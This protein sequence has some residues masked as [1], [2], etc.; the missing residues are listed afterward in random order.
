M[1]LWAVVITRTANFRTWSLLTW[2]LLLMS[3]RRDFSGNTT[4][5]RDTVSPVVMAQSC[6][7]CIPVM[8]TCTLWP[9]AISPVPFGMLSNGIW[10]QHRRGKCRLEVILNDACLLLKECSGT[11]LHKYG[12]LTE[13]SLKYLKINSVEFN[14]DFGM[15]AA[16]KIRISLENQ[17]VLPQYSVN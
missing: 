7:K 17:N 13:K 4:E 6:Q 11:F 16:W 3:K 8:F 9:L 10:S 5:K 2:S 1:C 15:E 14:I 12:L